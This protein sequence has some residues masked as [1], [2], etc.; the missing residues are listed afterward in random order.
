[1]DNMFPYFLCK[2]CKTKV[3]VPFELSIFSCACCGQWYIAIANPSRGRSHSVFPL[4][5]PVSASSQDGHA[6]NWNVVQIENITRLGQ[7]PFQDEIKNEVKN[8]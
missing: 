6:G 4:R 7:Y 2:D 8:G 3:E 5:K 1:M